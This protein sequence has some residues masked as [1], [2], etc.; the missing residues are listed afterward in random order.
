VLGIAVVQRLDGRRLP[1]AM[2][3]IGF[4][5]EEGVR[6]GTPFIGSRAVAGTLDDAVLSLTDAAG[7][8]VRDAITAYGLDVKE[9]PAARAGA[10]AIGYF[11]MH[12]EQGPVLD[13]LGLPVGVVNAIAGQTRLR[14]TFS[15]SANHAGTT[16][17]EG[18]RDALTGAA[19]WIL[20]VEREARAGTGVVA[21]VGRVDVAP[22]A[23]NVI[24]GSCTASLDVRHFHD[25]VRTG[26]VERLISLAREIARRR[27][28]TVA[29]E[30]TLDQAAVPMNVELE[31]VLERAVTACG[32]PLHVLPSGAGHDAMI[33]A[34]RMPA[35]MLFLRTP[36]G[37]SHHP[38]E[39]VREEDVEAAIRVGVRFVEEL[40]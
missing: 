29:V 23:T 32:Y 18:R 28:L 31:A 15:G 24:A 9:L 36:G 5:E 35:A 14:V 10:D 17:M 4:S 38:D 37:V 20:S 3:V 19:E 7:R 34:P 11:E 12:I 6:F 21:T 27:Q 33:L 22:G 40:A 2:E 16:P 26:T 8:T 39:A 30:A 13:T 25:G 1:F